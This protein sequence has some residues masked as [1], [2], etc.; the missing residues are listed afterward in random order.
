MTKSTPKSTPTRIDLARWGTA[1]ETRQCRH[2]LAS[3]LRCRRWSVR[4]PPSVSGTQPAPDPIP[5]LGE[6]LKAKCL[7]P[8]TIASAT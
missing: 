1:P 3:G 7:G 5:P 6:Q 2:I 4:A 8:S